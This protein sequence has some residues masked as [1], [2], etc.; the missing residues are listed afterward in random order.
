MKNRTELAKYFN[1]LGFK[2]GVEVGACFGY[3]S[4]VLC[5]NIPD[6]E[7]MAI[8]SWENKDN[9]R[10]EQTRGIGGEE[11]T[12]QVLEP[13]NAL[14]VKGKS[15]DVA[16]KIPDGSLDFVFIDADHGYEA[17]KADIAAW[18]PKVRKGGIVAG[19][20]YYVF[21]F[22]GK[23]DVVRA[24]NEYVEA[25]GLELLTTDRDPSNPMRDDRE[26]CWYFFK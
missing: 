26:P 7:L 20:D 8:D 17:V 15:L 25:N 19:H 16:P 22:S 4:K 12:R 23:D 1:E 24:V 21:H 18:A 3:Y 2:R 14:I 5:D 9:A 10:R 6:L 13:Y 11:H